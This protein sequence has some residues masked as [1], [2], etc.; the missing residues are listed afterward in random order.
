MTPIRFCFYILFFFIILIVSSACGETKILNE[1]LKKQQAAIY[2]YEQSNHDKT[3]KYCREA[4]DLWKI[5]KNSNI[6]EMPKW[7]IESNISDC[8]NILKRI[9]TSETLK[10]SITVPIRIVNNRYFADVILNKKEKATL[11]LDTGATSTVISPDVA[12]RLGIRPG[13]DAPKHSVTVF[14]GNTIEV[15]Y[16]S[17]S[18]VTLGGAVVKNITA[19]VYQGHPKA[20]FIDG[21]LGVDFLNHFTVTIDHV[22]S[23]LTLTPQRGNMIYG[24]RLVG[25]WQGVAR[26]EKMGSF[27]FFQDGKADFFMTGTSIIKEIAE[28]MGTLRYSF[29]ISKDPM[30]LDLI[31]VDNLERELKRMRLILKFISSEEILIKMGLDEERPKDFFEDDKGKTIQL[32]KIK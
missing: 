17:L 5:L 11:L 2:Y 26:D 19:G 9:S 22:S 3:E 23:R 7:A 12:G 28:G 21:I 15:P 10:A 1:A 27:V 30:E 20:P 31:V 16:V 4:I 14:G 24:D 8:R 29:D 13:E 6:H 25:E 32:K 18:N